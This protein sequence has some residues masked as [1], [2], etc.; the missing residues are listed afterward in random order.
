[1]DT[2]KELLTYLIDNRIFESSAS[3]L[4]SCLGYKGRMAFSRLKEGNIRTSTVDNIINDICTHFDLN[5]SD[6]VDITD[7]FRIGRI[8]YD[9]INDGNIYGDDASRTDRILTDFVTHS[10]KDYPYDFSPFIPQLEELH[11]DRPYVYFGSVMVLYIKMK[12]IDP[13]TGNTEQFHNLLKEHTS[14]ICSVLKQ[15][16]PENAIGHSTS[17]AY[18]SDNLIRSVPQCIWGLMMNNIHLLRYFADPDYI[19]SILELGAAFAEWEDLS[20]WHETNVAYSKGEKLWTLFFRESNSPLHG[21]YLGQTFEAGKDNETFIPKENFSLIFW[22]KENDDD[23]FATIQACNIINSTTENYTIYYGLYKYDDISNEIIIK[24]ND[25]NENSL[26]IPS[27][28][29]RIT[30]EKPAERDEQVWWNIIRRFDENDSLKLFTETLLDRLNTEY[31]DDDYDIQD[32]TISRK[33]FTLTI[34]TTD[35]TKEYSIPIDAYSF[36]RNLRVF[37]EVS[38]KKD[39]RTEELFVIW[40]WAGYEIPLSEFNIRTVQ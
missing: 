7:M 4:A 32:V 1:M 17:L 26:N 21:M 36:L 24:W 11:R 2:D 9:T 38:I 3:A 6:L 37:D 25:E 34:E 5:Y 27:R 14:N 22:E 30:R 10:F 20:Y 29:K 13:Y 39:T 23:E 18:L 16:I 15:H 28:L 33:F 19:N 31:L 12:K 35:G 40:P 8:L